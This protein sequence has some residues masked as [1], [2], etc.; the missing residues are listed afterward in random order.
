[1]I[2]EHFERERILKLHVTVFVNVSLCM[3]MHSVPAL[4][5]VHWFQVQTNADRRGCTDAASFCGIRDSVYPDRRSMGYPFDRQP[6]NGV[7]TLQ[8][9]LT[10]N[11]AVQDVSI[12]FT[13]RIVARPQAK[14]KPKWLLR[15][16][17]RIWILWHWR[18]ISTCELNVIYA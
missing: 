17:R 5:F 13:D 6:R 12:R 4:M 8:Q 16:W 14:A 1:M 7:D 10:P 11:M 2:F 18:G 15:L 9:F 3:K